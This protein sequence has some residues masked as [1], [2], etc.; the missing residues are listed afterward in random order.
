MKTFLLRIFRNHKVVLI[1]LLFFTFVVSRIS[2]FAEIKSQVAF[3]ESLLRNEGLVANP[4][5]LS[6]TVL[7]L[8]RAGSIQ[9]ARIAEA[10]TST[11]V[12][13]DSLSRRSKC[14]NFLA[15]LNLNTF[16]FHAIN[17]LEYRVDVV[18]SPRIHLIIIEFLVYSLVLAGYFA[19]RKQIEAG[20]LKETLALEKEKVALEKIALAKQVSHDIR[21]PVSALNMIISAEDITP[22]YRDLAKQ[23][24]KRINVIADSLLAKSKGERTDRTQAETVN[25][26]ALVNEI[27]S[28][29]KLQYKRSPG[30]EFEF[31]EGTGARENVKGSVVELGRVISNL[32]NNSVEAF[33]VNGG[34]VTIKLKK[35]A[36]GPTQLFVADNGKGIPHHII[37]KLGREGFSYGK[38][39]EKGSGSGLG[40]FHAKKTIEQ[41]G[42]TL[43]ISSQ[44]GSGTEIVIQI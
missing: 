25:L 9:C 28:E 11:L 4:Y 1:F 41:M 8:E 40:L 38:D 2:N 7:D 35:I 12:F 43:K 14:D 5:A 42:G 31:I 23:A 29:K 10:G 22:D 32:V 20:Q 27:I 39:E 3:I 15:S 30:I 17:G 16:N 37:E 19:F 6:K 18:V 33:G 36:S 26:Y 44:V 21:S 24:I 13:Y 34:K